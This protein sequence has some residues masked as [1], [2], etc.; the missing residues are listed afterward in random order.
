MLYDNCVDAASEALNAAGLNPGYTWYGT[1]N[2]YADP[3]TD[4][5]SIPNHRFKKMAKNNH[6]DIK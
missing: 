3:T 1:D 5:S 4:K 6:V 2:P